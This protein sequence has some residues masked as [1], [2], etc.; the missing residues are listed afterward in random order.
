MVVEM[1]VPIPDRRREKVKRFP[2]YFETGSSPVMVPEC[3]RPRDPT[4]M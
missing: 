2:N 1:D 4:M 3:E